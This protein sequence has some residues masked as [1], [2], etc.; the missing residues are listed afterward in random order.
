MISHQK[1]D[2]AL[3]ELNRWF[4]AKKH[5]TGLLLIFVFLTLNCSKT[6]EDE[7]VKTDVT[8]A[9]DKEHDTGRDPGTDRFDTGVSDVASTSA[10]PL[11]PPPQ[12][13]ET[14]FVGD[15]MF[16]RYEEEGLVANPPD[17]KNAFRWVG[18][19]LKADLAVVNLETPLLSEPF[20]KCPW[21][22]R[23]RFAA[24]PE[25]A[26][27]LVDAGFHVVSL[28]NNHVFDMRNKG[29]EDTQ[30]ILKEKKLI[31]VGLP[32]SKG[33]QPFGITQVTAAGVTVALIAVTTARNSVDGPDV[34]DLPYILKETALPALIG[35]L[36]ETARKQYDRVIVIAHWG[37]A[38][39]PRPRPPRRDTARAL[40]DLGA[41]AVIGHGPHVLQG[42][43]LY[44]QGLIVH[45]LGD[46]LFD[47][48]WD[49]RRLTGVL[50]VGYAPGRKC[51]S[52]VTFHPVAAVQTPEGIVPKPARGL[53]RKSVMDR[54][55]GLS[56]PMGT[57]WENQGDALVLKLPDACE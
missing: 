3:I 30:S 29:V 17:A 45:S 18:D 8:A 31:A 19:L 39:E 15:V 41:D 27:A 10:A 13:L 35:P 32:V 16:G 40:I 44:K 20:P 4:F 49:E 47:V 21:P 52:H 22:P 43:E 14:A 11:Q 12:I 23:L 46:F 42:I 25:A 5:Q 7:S 48:V 55:I 54:M 34:P 1:K 33:E 53:L 26:D 2:R 37:V 36:I 28:A 38:D 50:R 51:P 24:G 56:R 6:K 57:V 9:S